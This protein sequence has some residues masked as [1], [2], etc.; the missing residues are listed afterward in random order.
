MQS[1]EQYRILFEN[2]QEAIVVLQGKKIVFFNPKLREMTGYTDDELINMHF[3][4]VLHRNDLIR[5][6]EMYTKISTSQSANQKLQF[7]LKGKNNDLHWV[8]FSS[9]LIKWNN[10]P[11]GLLFVNDINEQKQAEQL[12]ELLIKISN[13]Y[14]N[15]SIENYEHTIND[16]LQ[17]IAEFVKSDRSYIFDY[18]WDNQVCNNTFE[19]CAK[20]I[21]PEIENL[22][23]VPL[24]YL[25]QCMWIMCKNLK[26]SQVCA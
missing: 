2:A 25:P 8:E 11:A 3:I 13:T 1:E 26:P 21:T 17:E 19:W 10:K 24:E 18:D 7:R 14:I 4:S 20:G 6:N 16:S 9:V 15:A 12:K 22:Q 5:M 23:K